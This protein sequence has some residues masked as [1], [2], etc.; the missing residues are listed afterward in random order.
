[1]YSK[2]A[3]WNDA[4]ESRAILMV[5]TLTTVIDGRKARTIA[6]GYLV[7]EDVRKA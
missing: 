4:T 5:A 7:R 2:K 3:T 6:I 1:M